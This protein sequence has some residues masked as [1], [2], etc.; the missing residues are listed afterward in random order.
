VK[1]DGISQSVSLY[2]ASQ[3]QKES[4]IFSIG[5]IALVQRNTVSIRAVADTYQTS[6]SIPPLPIIGFS[7]VTINL[8]RDH[9]AQKYSGDSLGCTAYDKPIDKVLSYA[10]FKPVNLVSYERPIDGTGIWENKIIATMTDE[11]PPIY[12]IKPFMNG[13]LGIQ[14][15]PESD[16]DIRNLV[17]TLDS[18]GQKKSFDLPPEID[19]NDIG[20][21]SLIV[22]DASSSSGK[23]LITNTNT[24]DLYFGTFENGVITYRNSKVSDR[25][26]GSSNALICALNDSTAYCYSGLPSNSPESEI[27]EILRKNAKPSTIETIDF[28]K[29][30]PT[31]SVHELSKEIGVNGLHVTNTK[32]VYLTSQNESL[33]DD[34]Y[35]VQLDSE[36]VMPRPILTDISS[37]SFG[38][39]L[40]YVQNNAIYKIDDK[41]NESYLVFSSKNL[42]I[43]NIIP[44]GDDI[45]FNAFISKMTDQKIH[46]YKLL[47]Y[48]SN[49]PS[50]KRLVD[51]LPLYMGSPLLNIDYIDDTIRVRVFASST[52]DRANNRLLYDEG[53]YEANR[54]TIENELTSLGITSDKYKILYS[55]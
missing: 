17:F 28:S 54:I 16:K 20:S 22:S 1:H 25:Y 40:L 38:D 41:K 15:Q 31:V 44:I 3:N 47:N 50:G 18:N 24:G 12:S 4:S 2:N 55:K 34:I 19:R 9:D 27:D 45:F 51:L 6:K 32:N 37:T 49:L 8:Y 35:T 26:D 30:I 39:G 5:D 48:V 42:K 43:S 29:T 52:V 36:T 33:L 7:S 11:Y 21:L 46:T 14:Q 23:F 53:E 13:V 10:C